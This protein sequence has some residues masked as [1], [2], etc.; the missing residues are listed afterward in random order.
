MC[1]TQQIRY[2]HYMHHP[3]Y[4]GLLGVGSV[5]AERKAFAMPALFSSAPPPLRV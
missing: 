5:C 4:A 1:E 3:D 2:V